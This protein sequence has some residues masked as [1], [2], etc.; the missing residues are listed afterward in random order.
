[1]AVLCLRKGETVIKGILI[2]FLLLE[3]F[4]GRKSC[5]DLCNK[6]HLVLN[7]VKVIVFHLSV[8]LDCLENERF[9]VIRLILKLCW[10]Y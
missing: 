5:P 6:Y 8:E 7:I 4:E 9:E 1:M 3:H 10:Y 2:C